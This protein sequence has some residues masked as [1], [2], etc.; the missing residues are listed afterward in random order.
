MDLGI[1]LSP[2]RNG[3]CGRRRITT[4]RTDRKIRDICIQNRKLPVCLLMNN[5][6]DD[7]LISQRTV[8]RRLAENEL[9]ARK[10]ARK[11]KLT[12]VMI[13]K[14]VDWAGKYINFTIQDW[15]KVKIYAT[16]AI[17]HYY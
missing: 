7:G 8:Q 2:K 9:I 12:P 10:P 6:R 11:A 3:E 14:R 17:G 5:I 1:T 13:K 16:T 15:E 4:P